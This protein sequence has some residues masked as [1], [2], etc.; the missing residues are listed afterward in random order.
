MGNGYSRSPKLL[1]GAIIQFSAAMI[2]PI[3]NFIIF[4]YNP[5]T[6]TRTLSPYDPTFAASV[7]GATPEERTAR[8]ARIDHVNAQPFDPSETFT[9]NLFLDATDALEAPE[10]HPVAFVSGV[11]DRI[12]ALEM[13]LYPA[14]DSVIGGLLGTA[15]TS[16]SS[17]SLGA[18]A[19]QTPE[20]RRSVPT[21]LFFFGTGRIVPVRLT[22]FSVEELQFNQLLYPH[23]AKVAVTMRVVTADEIKAISPQKPEHDLAVAAYQFTRGQKEVLALANL[24]NTVESL[25][26]PFL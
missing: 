2:L 1:K 25:I 22:G 7:E 21:T 17:S 5:E 8:T 19:T 20:P 12:A 18:E 6:L 10:Y 3:P 11:A 14:G 16:L 15:A 24:A 13:L 23:R 9:L 4:Q 26:L